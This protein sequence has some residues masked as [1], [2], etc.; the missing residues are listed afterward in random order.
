[1]WPR[2]RVNFDH[3]VR[4]EERFDFNTVTWNSVNSLRGRYRLRLRHLFAAARPDRF[5]RAFG[6]GEFFVTLAGEEGVQREQFRVT[7]GLER[8]FSRLMRIRAQ[9]TW[10]QEELF[11]LPSESADA[12]YFRLRVYQN[13]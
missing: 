1:M 11:F 7:L 10:Q 6:S 8:S 3:Y 9:V 4:L 2:S 12:V 13:F 5:W